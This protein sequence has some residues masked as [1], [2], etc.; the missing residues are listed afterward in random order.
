MEEF[1][2][3]I[4]AEPHN[5]EIIE[6]LIELNFNSIHIWEAHSG[7]PGR[8]FSKERYRFITKTNNWKKA[9]GI[10]WNY[11]K[12]KEGYV[13]CAQCGKKFNKGGVMH[14]IDF[15]NKMC[16]YH[17]SYVK[18][19]CSKGCHLKYHPEAMK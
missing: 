18:F 19:L 15:Y 17:P 14:H 12:D 10:L 5:K 6:S 3:L 4:D 9:K 13:I 11:N 2:A 16:R 1:Q 7:Y 8:P